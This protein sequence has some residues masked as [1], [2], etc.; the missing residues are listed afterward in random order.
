LRFVDIAARSEGG[1]PDAELA[2]VLGYEALAVE[3]LK[4]YEC[5]GRVTLVPRHT[6][7]LDTLS[8]VPRGNVLRVFRAD[9]R[10]R[11]KLTNRVVALAHAVEVGGELLGR[12]GRKDLRKLVNTIPHVIVRAD[13]VYL[14]LTMAKSLEGLDRLLRAYEAG[15]IVLSIGSGNDY[16]A[17]TG[18]KHGVVLAALLVTFGLSEAKALASVTSNPKELLR[19]AGY[20]VK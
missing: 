17:R 7:T 11:L 10:A 2:R 15:K 1:A 18:L 3:G 5:V 14:R 13:E 8:R 9:S 20:A 4:R 19:C 16:A 6:F 12:L